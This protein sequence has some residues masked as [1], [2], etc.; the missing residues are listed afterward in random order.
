MNVLFKYV[1]WLA[2]DLILSVGSKEGLLFHLYIDFRC[3]FIFVM[4]HPMILSLWG[5][6]VSSCPMSTNIQPANMFQLATNLLARLVSKSVLY[7]E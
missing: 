6:I 2:C 7:F 4:F 5:S 1:R 3:A